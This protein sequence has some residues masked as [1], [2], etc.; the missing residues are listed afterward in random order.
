MV[1]IMWHHRET[2]RRT[3]KTNIKVP[4]L[5]VALPTSATVSEKKSWALNKKVMF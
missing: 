4:G 3:E 1:E 2:R 5:V